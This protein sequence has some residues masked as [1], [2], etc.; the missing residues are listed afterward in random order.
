M[1]TNFI[2][3]A[4][5]RELIPEDEFVIEKVVELSDRSFSCFI[6]DPLNDY[7]FIR[8][9]K[10]HMW[11]DEHEVWHCILVKCPG[12]DFGILVNSEGSNYARYSAGV[13]LIC[14]NEG[15]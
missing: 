4:E 1:R 14:L 9:N 12:C 7:D 5:P 3:K 11:I 15:K 8:D 13:P 6:H 10:E 2:R